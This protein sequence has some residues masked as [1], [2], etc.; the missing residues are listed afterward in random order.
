MNKNNWRRLQSFSLT[1]LLTGLGLGSII[2]GLREHVNV[3]VTP[4][5]VVKKG[6]E[7]N[8][9]PIRLG[10]VV[11]K[12][13]IG[14]NHGVISFTAVEPESTDEVKIVFS[15]IPPSL[16]KE[17]TAMIAEGKIVDGVLYAD[18]LLAKHDENYQ[19]KPRKV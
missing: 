4:G 5:F 6:K 10:G 1:M 7:L 14:I 12:N 13:S 8:H 16:F 18:R 2:Y 17:E 19:P 3:F 9:K 11:K 15:G